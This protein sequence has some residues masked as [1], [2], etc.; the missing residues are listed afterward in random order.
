[1]PDVLVSLTE[2]RENLLREY[3]VTRGADRA[4]ILAKILEVES[5][6]EDEKSRRDFFRSEN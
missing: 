1:M 6:M 3:V 4:A 2:A 5:E